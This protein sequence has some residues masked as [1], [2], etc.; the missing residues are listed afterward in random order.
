[1]DNQIRYIPSKYRIRIESKQKESSLDNDQ[2]TIKNDN[3]EEK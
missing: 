2:D 1:M 3:M